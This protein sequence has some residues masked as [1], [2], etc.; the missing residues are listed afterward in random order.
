MTMKSSAEGPF[1]ALAD[2]VQRMEDTLTG[3]GAEVRTR[4]LVVVDHQDEERIVGEVESGGVAELRM[5]LPGRSW[6]NRT[7]VMLF[8]SP[9]TPFFE[10]PPGTG[11]HLWLDGEPIKE[12]D[13]WLDAD[14][15]E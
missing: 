8:S 6:G 4:R 12:F 10:L 13:I 5:D 15:E 3:M 9:G 2:R 11:I 14:A 1:D 7:T